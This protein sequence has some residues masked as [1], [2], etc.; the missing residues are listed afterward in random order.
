[1]SEPII[2]GECGGRNGH[3]TPFCRFVDLSDVIAEP[4]IITSRAFIPTG[5]DI[6]PMCRQCGAA[7]EQHRQIERGIGKLTASDIATIREIL[8][9]VLDDGCPCADTRHPWE[10]QE[11]LRSPDGDEITESTA[12]EQRYK[13]VQEV[14]RR[15]VTAGAPD[16]APRSIQ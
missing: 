2:C 9:E 10:L 4:V 3:T 5:V 11:G 13:F 16:A 1:M 12:T 15:I 7:K 6:L 8:F 14:Q